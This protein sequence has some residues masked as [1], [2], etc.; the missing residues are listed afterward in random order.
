RGSNLHVHFKNTCETA[1]A[2]KALPIWKATKYRKDVTLQKL[3]TVP[4]DKHCGWAHGWWPRENADS[5]AELQGLDV[6]ALVIEHSQVNKAF[7]MRHRTYRAHGQ[8]NPYVSS[9]CHIEMI[10]PEKE[11]IEPEEEV[12]QKKKISQ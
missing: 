12:A 11:H 7:K 5:N 2:M 9:P 4:K 3:C 8:T 6:D 10:F 1:K